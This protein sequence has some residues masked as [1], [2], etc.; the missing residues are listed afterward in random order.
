MRLPSMRAVVGNLLGLAVLGSAGVA[1]GNEI[2]LLPSGFFP[3]ASSGSSAVSDVFGWLLSVSGYLYVSGSSLPVFS[4]LTAT[5]AFG[6]LPSGT[7]IIDGGQ[8]V[9]CVADTVSTVY[10]WASP[11]VSAPELIAANPLGVPEPGGF[12]LFVTAVAA[13]VFAVSRWRGRR[14]G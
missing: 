4:G 2:L 7:S 13:I 10:C 14:A 1:L 9:P 3:P 11:Y 6:L 12:A 8:Y 5:Q